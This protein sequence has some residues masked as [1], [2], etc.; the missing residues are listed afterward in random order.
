M[1]ISVNSLNNVWGV[2]PT[3]V[4]HVGAHEAEELDAYMRA[5]WT[6]ITWVEVQPLKLE[7]LRRK[8]PKESNHIIEAAIWGTS[9]IELTLKITNNTEST[10]LL[11]LD[12][13]TFRHPDVIVESIIKVTTTTLDDLRLPTE[14]DYLS[15]DI[16]GSELQALVG[17]QKGIKDVNWIYTEV[18]K[19]ELYKG[20]AIVEEIDL[21]L[22][23]EGF[24]REVTVWTKYGWGDALYVR[25]GMLSM[26]RRVFGKFWIRFFYAKNFYY[27]LK[28]SLK[29]KLQKTSP[30]IS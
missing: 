12:T 17:F 27:G 1:L 29:M 10:S 24:E 2:K 25:K 7:I 19:E 8:L 28:H 22:T 21:F 18:N 15:L 14:V 3:G 11:D 23:K 4:L 30:K 9:G 20:C 5:N 16:Q 6:P 26:R 13:H